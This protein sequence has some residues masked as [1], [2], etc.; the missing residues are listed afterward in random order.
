MNY[1]EQSAVLY[2]ADFLSMQENNHPITDTCKYFFIHNTP[3]NSCF[4][5]DLEPFYDPENK[6]YKQALTQFELIKAKFG[7]EG[8]RSFIEDVCDI[9]ACGCVSGERMLQRIHQYSTKK[10]KEH[11]LNTYNNWKN[12]LNYKHIIKDDEGKPIIAKCTKEIA[13][14]EKALGIRIESS[15]LESSRITDKDV[16]E[17]S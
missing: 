10:Q 13:H 8:I 2:Y 4:L 15:L 6:Y 11:A 16:E 14:I 12:N 5:L 7:D 1:F 3:I 17:H 9:K